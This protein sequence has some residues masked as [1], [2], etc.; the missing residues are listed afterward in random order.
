MK[1]QFVTYSIA[2]KLKKLGFNEDC[3]GVIYSDGLVATGTPEFVR[4]MLRNDKDCI[5]AILYQQAFD[6]FREKGYHT[7][8]TLI[9]SWYFT[10]KDKTMIH[11]HGDYSSFEKAR[12]G[13]I[14]TLIKRES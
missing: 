10:I 8:I 12:I 5:K 6:W 13:C 1:R 7:E 2:L 11:N 4:I 14:E 3:L 9:Q